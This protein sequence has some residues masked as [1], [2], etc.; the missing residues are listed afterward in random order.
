MLLRLNSFL[1][2]SKRE[3]LY[4]SASVL[5]LSDKD[6]KL[7]RTNFTNQ[8]DIV[9]NDDNAVGNAIYLQPPNYKN[10]KGLYSF[11]NYVEIYVQ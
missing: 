8:N 2:L 5:S 6:S 11:Q 4:K 7:W 9:K 3:S 10:I 1:L